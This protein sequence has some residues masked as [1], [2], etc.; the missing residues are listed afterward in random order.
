MR[1]IAYSTSVPAYSDGFSEYRLFIRRKISRRTEAR[2]RC[3]PT[4]PPVHVLRAFF[5]HTL[6]ISDLP[7]RILDVVLLPLAGVSKRLHPKGRFVVLGCL[8]QVFV[9]ARS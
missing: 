3:R 7:M 4:P 9:G 6:G 2:C 8:L 5:A 1:F